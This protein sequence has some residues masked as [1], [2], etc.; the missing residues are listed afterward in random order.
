MNLGKEAASLG[1]SMEAELKMRV[2]E[3]QDDFI[4]QKILPFCEQ[5]MDREIKKKDLIHALLNYA[6]KPV[7]RIK[8]QGTLADCPTCYRLLDQEEYPVACGF[9]GQR[10]NWEEADE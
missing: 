3:T 4:I 1:Y 9:C 6:Q 10:L 8:H 7:R 2:I 5:E